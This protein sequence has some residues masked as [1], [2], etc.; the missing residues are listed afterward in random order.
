MSALAPLGGTAARYIASPVVKQGGKA[1]LGTFTKAGSLAGSVVSKIPGK[2][3]A[4]HVAINAGALG[5]S[6]Y[7]SSLIASP[8]KTYEDVMMAKQGTSGGDDVSYTDK[9]VRLV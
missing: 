6:Y 3:I 8:K 1:V 5:A 4:K 9:V 7:L 2:S